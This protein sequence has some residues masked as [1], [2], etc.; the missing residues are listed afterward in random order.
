MINLES[1]KLYLVKL[2]S[3]EFVM[4]EYK[5]DGDLVNTVCIIPTP[6][7]KTI[8]FDFFPHFGFFKDSD[9]K[10]IENIKS[11]AISFKLLSELDIL[12]KEYY[13]FRVDRFKTN[14]SGIIS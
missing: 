7:V 11:K 12:N 5:E 9:L 2:I 4:G 1:D 6:E 14:T 3:G 13:K 10:D 8:R